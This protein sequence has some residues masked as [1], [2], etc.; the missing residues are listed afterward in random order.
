MSDK[1]FFS[2][3][4]ID[5]K[6]SIIIPTYNHAKYIC[7]AIDSALNQTYKNIEVIVVDDGSTD[8]T[9]TIIDEKYNNK[10]TYIH[11]SNQGVS[12]ARN[13]GIKDSIGTWILTVDADDW[14]D[15]QYIEHAIK[16][17][18]DEKTIVT[19]R[20]YFVDSD[21]LPIDGSYPE[22][23]I[24]LSKT[25]LHKLVKENYVVTTSLFSK[26]MWK[27]TGGYDEFLHIA[28][29]WEFWINLVKN[30][31]NVIYIEGD[32]PYLKYRMHKN[33]QSD[34]LKHQLNN[35]ISYV[36]NKHN[37]QRILDISSLYVNILGSEC[38]HADLI[39]YLYSNLS[40][41]DIRKNLFLK[42]SNLVKALYQKHLGREADVSGLDHY[43]NS[44]MDI[45][46]IELIILNSHEY[47]H[48]EA[49]N[50]KP[51]MANFDGKEFE[52][53][54]HNRLKDQVISKAISIDKCWEP[55]IS[56]II[57]DSLKPDGLFIDIG[58]N[59]GWHT[60]IAQNAGYDVIAFEPEQ[61]N[62][63]IL[64]KNC[65][66]DGSILYKTA[67]G[68]VAATASLHC[69]PN[70]YGDVWISD[71]Q[72]GVIEVVR[73]DDVLDKSCALKTNV[74]KMDVQ[75]YETKIIQGGIEFFKNLQKGTVIITEISLWKQEFDLQ[76]LLDVLHTD[77]TESYALCNWW[78][79]EPV[80]LAEALEHA[81]KDL[82]SN[83][84]EF[85]LIIV[86]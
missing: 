84:F 45:H 2:S 74:V 16:K 78:N 75:G 18:N 24:D 63:D 81:S 11:Q 15:P 70:N 3:A 43:V 30:G 80:T 6:V 13:T 34:K 49:C 25:K 51:V 71:S 20:A 47:L 39:S 32:K 61:D 54:T 38:D 55:H 31:A 73:L 36:N 9:K 21:L 57:V 59:I 44:K 5:T 52:F 23:D 68:D 65:T 50:T 41:L 7:D 79:N 56:R 14:I 62:F 48:S 60:R 42:K 10:I 29:D 37:V 67:L 40:M 17:I 85:D 22:G 83:I 77:V 8:N 12:M 86:K 64:K 46:Q 27:L 66:K 4:P 33:K 58:A 19:S 26:Y 35:T 72:D 82:T 53:A 28:E 1:E 76:V 69:D